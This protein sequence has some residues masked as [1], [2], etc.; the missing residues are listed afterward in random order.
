MSNIELTVTEIK[1]FLDEL[2]GLGNIRVGFLDTTPNSLAA[3]YE[4][5]GFKA[6]GRFGVAGIGYERPTIQIVFRGEPND[7][8]NPAWKARRAYLALAAVQPGVL[9]A[10]STV[11]Q[12]IEPMQPPFSMGRDANLRFM[13]TCNYMI[14]KEPC[15]SALT[16]CP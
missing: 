9:Y 13:I 4:Y 11:Y 10:G 5:G 7:Y 14:T 15:S 1:T 16:D 8:A 3:I 6:D 12:M 2:G